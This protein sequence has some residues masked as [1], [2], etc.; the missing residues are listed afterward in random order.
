MEEGEARRAAIRV[1]GAEVAVALLFLALGGL[2][3]YDSVRLGIGWQEVHGPRPGYFPFYVGAIIVVAALVNIVNAL[4]VPDD[5]NATFVELGQLKLVLTVLVPA[6]VYAALVGWIGIY[7]SSILFIS[8]FMRWLG[9]YPWW[10]VAAVSL[11]AAAVFFVIFEIWFKVPLP[12]GPVE[13]FL[14]LD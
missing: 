12:K 10:K 11:G 8:F 9:K 1:K 7:V 3:I 2:V 4:R 6:A 13:S 14:H 5:K